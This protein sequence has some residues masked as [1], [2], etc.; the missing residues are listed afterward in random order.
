MV[1]LED[2]KSNFRRKKKRKKV[3]RTFSLIYYLLR[4]YI[5]FKYLEFEINEP[6]SF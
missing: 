4:V 5:Y 6:E 1:S 3:L 2:D